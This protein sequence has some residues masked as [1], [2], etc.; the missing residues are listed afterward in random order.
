[1]FLGNHITEVDPDAQL[2]PLLRRGGRVAIGHPALDLDR[3][4]DGIHNAG[5]LGQKTVAGVLYDPAPAPRSSD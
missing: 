3:T 5:K 4:P 2:D 1:V